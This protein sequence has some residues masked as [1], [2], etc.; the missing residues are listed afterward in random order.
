VLNYF[1]FAIS[2]LHRPMPKNFRPGLPSCYKCIILIS[3][4]AL[5]MQWHHF[6]KSLGSHF[7]FFLF[8]SVFFLLAPFPLFHTLFSSFRCRSLK[9]GYRVW[10]SA[11]Q[12]VLGQ[13][14]SQNRI[15]YISVLKCG[16]CW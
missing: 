12:R 8:P 4:C 1:H 16:I 7:L 5:Y 6:S 2:P 11:P 13:T 10:G 9:S 15:W 3:F 14:P